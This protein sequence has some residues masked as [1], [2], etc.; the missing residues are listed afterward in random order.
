[1]PLPCKSR[2]AN[3]NSE[4]HEWSKSNLRIICFGQLIQKFV[5]VMNVIMTK[6][7]KREGY[8][9]LLSEY[10]LTQDGDREYEASLKLYAVQLFFGFAIVLFSLCLLNHKPFTKAYLM[11]WLMSTSLASELPCQLVLP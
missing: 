3:K 11:P 10:P 8:A 2:N 4:D 6:G 7:R 1:M 9:E 5:I